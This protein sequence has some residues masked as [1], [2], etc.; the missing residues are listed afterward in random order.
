MATPKGI[1]FPTCVSVNECVTNNSPLESEAS[2]H[3]SVDERERERDKYEQN[4][5]D[6]G[7]REAYVTGTPMARWQE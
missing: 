1:A 3:V 7:G 4:G 5:F 6:V 2:K